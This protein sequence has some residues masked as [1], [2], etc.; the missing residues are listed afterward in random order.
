[1]KLDTPIDLSNCNQNTAE[2]TQGIELL[3]KA[4][5]SHNTT[6]IL[7]T[8]KT[9]AYHRVDEPKLESGSFICKSKDW[10]NLKELLYG[11]P[12]EW[13]TETHPSDAECAS[14]CKQ[15]KPVTDPTKTYF[16]FPGD[17]QHDQCLK[18]CTPKIEKA[19]Q[20]LIGKL[21]GTKPVTKIV[22]IVYKLDA[23]DGLTYQCQFGYQR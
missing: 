9:V 17:G 15:I 16:K 4:C 7:R 18:T 5:R 23:K 10:F 21:Y 11:E 8:D 22:K 13:D 20:G 19:C 6:K 14:T 12:D 2:Y 3:K 1:M